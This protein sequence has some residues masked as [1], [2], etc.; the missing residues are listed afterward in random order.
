MITRIPGH[1]TSHIHPCFPR[2]LARM[3]G[4]C[5]LLAG[6][7]AQGSVSERLIDFIVFGDEERWIKQAG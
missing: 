2:F 4:V 5:I 3:A 7:F 1:R 6:I